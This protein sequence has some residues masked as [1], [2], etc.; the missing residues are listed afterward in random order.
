MDFSEHA[1]RGKTRINKTTKKSTSL[2]IQGRIKSFFE[3]D[4]RLVLQLDER[5]ADIMRQF[6]NHALDHAESI[7]GVKQLDSYDTMIETYCPA[8]RNETISLKLPRTCLNKL[9]RVQHLLDDS[10]TCSVQLV[11]AGV[12]IGPEL[13]SYPGSRKPHGFWGQLF[14]VVDVVNI[15]TAIQ[16]G[17]VVRI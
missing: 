5:T 15:A 1:F 7:E 6:D 13:L 14:K 9:S 16:P 10:S 11:D 12:W 2:I 3:A 8:I 4:S 17:P